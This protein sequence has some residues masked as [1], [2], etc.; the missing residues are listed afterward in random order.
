MATGGTASVWGAYP[1]GGKEPPY[2]DISSICIAAIYAGA[3]SNDNNFY[4]TFKI[5][6]PLI[7]YDSPSSSKWE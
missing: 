5:V 3:G 2:A 1:L 4:A 7:M 6:K